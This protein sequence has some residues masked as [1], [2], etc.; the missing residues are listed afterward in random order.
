[1]HVATI[2]LGVLVPLFED[3]LLRGERPEEAFYVRCDES[4]NPP[5]SVAEG[6]FIVELGVAIAAPAEFLVFRLGRNEG[7]VEVLEES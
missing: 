1:L 3:G 2:A 6:R 4:V 5:E 7:V